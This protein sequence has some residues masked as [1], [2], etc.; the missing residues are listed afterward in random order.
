MK[1]NFC[2]KCGGKVK[3]KEKCLF[4]CRLCKRKEYIN[5]RTTNAII[6]ENKKGEIL[7]GKRKYN[8][9]KGLL[10]LLGGF[11][12]PG[13]TIEESMRREFKEETGG[14]LKELKYFGS[15]SDDY[16]FQNENLPTIVACFIGKLKNEKLKAG[17]DVDELFFIK[18]KNIRLNRIAFKSMKQFLKDYLKD[19]K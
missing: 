19:K 1:L 4:E 7:F 13:E 11:L 12:N 16:L 10:D 2:Q 3:K 8:P 14:S 6:I 9:K 17:D 18:K 5:P 15:Y